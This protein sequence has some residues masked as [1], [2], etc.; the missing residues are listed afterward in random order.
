MRRHQQPEHDEQYDLGEPCHAF[1]EM[2]DVLSRTVLPGAGHHGS[3]V[4][5]KKAAGAEKL[6]ETEYR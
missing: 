6:R 3:K 5:R 4:D 2:L 1:E